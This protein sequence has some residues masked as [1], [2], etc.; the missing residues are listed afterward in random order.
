[1]HT[2]QLKVEDNIYN[3]IMFML[4]NLSVDGLEIKEIDKENN[5]EIST[6]EKIHKLF[7]KQRIKPFLEID[8]PVKWQQELREEWS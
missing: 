7:S 1:M 4:T 2:I 6:K 3:N 5:N 8:D